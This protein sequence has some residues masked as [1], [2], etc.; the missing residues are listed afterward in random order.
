MAD[1]S[2]R[3]PR[4]RASRSGRT[5]RAASSPATSKST[6]ARVNASA[7]PVAGVAAAWMMRPVTYG[8]TTP[9]V[10]TSPTVI[11]NTAPRWWVGLISPLAVRP[12]AKT[13]VP[14]LNA[15]VISAIRSPPPDVIGNN[16][17]ARPEIMTAIPP[18]R[19]RAIRLDTPRCISHCVATPCAMVNTA[20]ESQG[21]VGGEAGEEAAHPG[22]AQ[23]DPAV[24]DAR[25]VGQVAQCLGSTDGCGAG[26]GALLAE[27]RPQQHP[28]H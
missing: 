11:A 14:R 4:W 27:Y 5:K 25:L 9:A 17:I 23:E 28:R 16:T 24:G 2:S 10:V 7:Y 22:T 21:P 8:A 20:N 12:M 1:S 13:I 6:P 26:D 18:R 3:N 19:P 15:T